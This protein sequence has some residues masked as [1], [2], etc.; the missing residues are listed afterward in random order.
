[1]TVAGTY[2]DY[3]LVTGTSNNR[4]NEVFEGM[5]VL[6]L[7]G[8]GP[9]GEL[10]YDANLYDCNTGYTIDQET[11]ITELLVVRVLMAAN[12][13]RALIGEQYRE[14]DWNLEVIQ[15]GP[16]RHQPTLERRQQSRIS[17]L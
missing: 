15:H 5:V 1:M 4:F 11:K 3:L 17:S 14:E 7:K 2:V 8:P 6:Y 10:S 9:S 13:V 16:W 12:L